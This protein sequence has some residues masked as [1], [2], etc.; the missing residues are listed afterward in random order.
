MKAREIIEKEGLQ[1]K[2]GI[3]ICAVRDDLLREGYTEEEVYDAIAGALPYRVAVAAI[4][5]SKR[6]QGE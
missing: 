6:Q 5:W 3:P 1:E 4:D 2:I